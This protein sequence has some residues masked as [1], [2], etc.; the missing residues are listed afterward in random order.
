MQ[1]SDVFLTRVSMCMVSSTIGDPGET[2]EVPF[3]LVYVN[4]EHDKCL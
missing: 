1:V 2:I 4:H 3:Q